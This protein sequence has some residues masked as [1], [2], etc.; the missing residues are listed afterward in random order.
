MEGVLLLSSSWYKS[1]AESGVSG[2]WSLESGVGSLESGVSGVW[3]LESGVW[4]L[5]SLESLEYKS[6]ESEALIRS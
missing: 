3:S 5:W 6:L 4:S 1:L 2:V